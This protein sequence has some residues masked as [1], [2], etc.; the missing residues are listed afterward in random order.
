MRVLGWAAD[1]GVYL[2]YVSSSEIYGSSTDHPQPE[3]YWGYANPIRPRSPCAEA[4]RAG[5]ALSRCYRIHRGF[6]VRIARLFNVCGPGFRYGDPRMIPRFIQ[7]AEAGEPLTVYGTGGTT[8]SFCY[9]D[10]IVEGLMLLMHSHVE[11]PVNLGFPEEIKIKELA[12][13][14]V[15]L[16]AVARPGFTLCAFR[17][18]ITRHPRKWC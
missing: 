17:L 2:V 1:N 10:D 6:S 18:R 16:T 11:E 9:V 7:A 15:A 8:R 12:K 5:E 14:V 4:K 13:L 3:S